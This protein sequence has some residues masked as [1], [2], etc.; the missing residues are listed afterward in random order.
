MWR[1]A[2][3]FM[4]DLVGSGYVGNHALDPAAR[5]IPDQVNAMKFCCPNLKVSREAGG[6]SRPRVQ[7][8]PRD[9]VGMDI[10]A[11]S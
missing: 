10:M 5:A 1:L 2:K 6:I 7:G 8:K 4:S 3:T 11:P 9:Q